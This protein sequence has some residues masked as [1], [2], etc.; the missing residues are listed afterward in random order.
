VLITSG[1]LK[2]WQERHEN[3]EESSPSARPSPTALTDAPSASQAC[4]AMRGVQMPVL[5]WHCGWRP[6]ASITTLHPKCTFMKVGSAAQ[7]CTIHQLPYGHT[8]SLHF[9]RPVISNS[10]Q[11][12]LNCHQKTTSCQYK[13]VTTHQL[14]VECPCT[15]SQTHS[16]PEKPH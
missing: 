8:V 2:T 13:L 7:A 10:C 15:P 5:H 6:R 1:S 11:T 4:C 3:V 16:Y 12:V 14:S 9:C